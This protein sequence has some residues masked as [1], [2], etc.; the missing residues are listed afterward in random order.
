MYLLTTERDIKML[1]TKTSPWTG[2]ENS[3]EIAIDEFTLFRIDNPERH[4]TIQSIVPN[5]SAEEREF[6]MTGATAQDWEEM[7][8]E[9]EEG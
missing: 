1:I 5:L 2:K 8:P 7:F 9:E 3:M 6:I 4:E